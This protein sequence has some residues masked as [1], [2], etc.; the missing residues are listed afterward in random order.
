MTQEQVYDLA[1]ESHLHYAELPTERKRTSSVL[2]DTKLGIVQCYWLSGTSMTRTV[3]ELWEVLH[4]NGFAIW[5]CSASGA[6]P[7]MAAVD[8]FGLHDMC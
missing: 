3:H 5:A 2:E 4:Q 6:Y 8:A 1:Y 7:V